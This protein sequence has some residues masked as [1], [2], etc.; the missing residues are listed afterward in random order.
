MRYCFSAAMLCSFVVHVICNYSNYN[1]INLTFSPI[2]ISTNQHSRPHY[3]RYDYRNPPPPRH[4]YEDSREM[5]RERSVSDVG[6]PMP[7]H[8]PLQAPTNTSLE[9]GDNNSLRAVS[10]SFSANDSH[11]IVHQQHVVQKGGI[12]VKHSPGVVTAVDSMEGEFVCVS[13]LYTTCLLQT[14]NCLY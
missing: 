7:T 14:R 3:D 6:G 1:V 12:G 9:H 10:S 8:V 11:S 4:Y 2:C 13:A 5:Y